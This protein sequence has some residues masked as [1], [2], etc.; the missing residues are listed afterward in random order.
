MP[1]IA[2]T[3]Q[4]AA[5]AQR[6]CAGFDAIAAGLERIAQ[7]AEF[8]QRELGW[9][10]MPDDLREDS[11]EALRYLAETLPKTN[12]F[13][14]DVRARLGQCGAVLRSGCYDP[15]ALRLLRLA[16][17]Y[18]QGAVDGVFHAGD[19]ARHVSNADPRFKPCHTLF[20]WATLCIRED[21][22]DLART[23]SDIEDVVL[24]A[25]WGRTL[26]RVLGDG[27]AG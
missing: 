2:T 11:E 14:V 8:L 13:V 9:V 18:L 17:W 10:L 22:D 27:H 19:A 16:R 6:L 20:W 15:E 25:R 26:A 12:Q 3:A 1:I 7:S 23:V 5:W 24:Q 21:F 4:E